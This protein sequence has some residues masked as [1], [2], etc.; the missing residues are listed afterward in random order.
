MI[1]T[2]SVETLLNDED[3]FRRVVVASL[4]MRKKAK[5]GEKHFVLTRKPRF[6]A[7]CNQYRC[8]VGSAV[9]TA[10]VLMALLEHALEGRVGTELVNKAPVY[11]TLSLLCTQHPQGN[12]GS[13]KGQF[14]TFWF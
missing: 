11:K 3:S 5:S 2:F 8:T 9:T 6:R 12:G 7:L 13:C 14:V 1:A 10:I 4:L